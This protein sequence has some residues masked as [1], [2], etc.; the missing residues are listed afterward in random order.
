MYFTFGVGVEMNHNTDPVMFELDQEMMP[1]QPFQP[2]TWLS[3]PLAFKLIAY[4]VM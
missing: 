3:F 2:L 1:T 4:N